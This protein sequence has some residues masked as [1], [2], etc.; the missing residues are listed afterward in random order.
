MKVNANIISEMA[1]IMKLAF[2]EEEQVTLVEDI[3]NTLSML[4]TLS[5]VDTDGIEGTFY[6][7]VEGEARFRAD[8]P[9]RNPEEVAQLLEN[10]TD[11]EETHIRVPAILEDGEG[12]A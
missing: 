8:E 6:G 2:T 11:H 9:V 7:S 1:S 12:G 5:E 4:A 3:N 10:A